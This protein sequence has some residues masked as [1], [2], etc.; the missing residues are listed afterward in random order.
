VRLVLTYVL[1][2]SLSF[3]QCITSLKIK[4]VSFGREERERERECK[5]QGARLAF[6]RS[7]PLSSLVSPEFVFD[8]VAMDPIRRSTH[9]QTHESS[10]L[11]QT[12]RLE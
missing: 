1:F 6:T 8:S 7:D 5:E 3:D 2:P 11:F 10:S 9:D 12:V 4:H